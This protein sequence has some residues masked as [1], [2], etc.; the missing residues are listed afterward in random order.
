MID[1]LVSRRAEKLMEEGLT[2]AEQGDFVQ[3]R[4]Q[5]KR[6]AEEFLTADALAYWGWMEHQ[7]G[8]T[9]VAINLCRKAIRVDPGLGNPYNDIGSY[10][11]GLGKINEAIPWLEKAITANRY[12]PR[13][14]PHINLGRIYLMKSLPMRALKEFREANRICPNSE[15]SQ[16]IEAIRRQLN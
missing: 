1:D 3:A 6:S 9:L 13:H 4:D 12:E 2:Q 7:L 14:F 10:L 5:F 16:M 8:N 15:I 11:L